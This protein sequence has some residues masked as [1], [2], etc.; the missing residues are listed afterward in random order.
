MRLDLLN[1]YSLNLDRIILSL[2]RLY[3]HGIDLRVFTITNHLKAT[4]V[5]KRLKTTTNSVFQEK[6]QHNCILFKVDYK[7]V[8]ASIYHY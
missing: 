8:Y 2:R 7:I 6:T 4:S 3:N 1:P 5:I